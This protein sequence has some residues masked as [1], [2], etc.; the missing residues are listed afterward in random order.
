LQLFNIFADILSQMYLKSVYLYFMDAN[1]SRVDMASNVRIVGE[2]RIVKDVEGSD[3][4]VVCGDS[5]E[6]A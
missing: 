3:R 2:Q 1:I 6:F 4:G 5:S